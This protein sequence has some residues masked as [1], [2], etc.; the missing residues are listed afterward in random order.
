MVRERGVEAAGRD[1][2][3]HNGEKKMPGYYTPLNQ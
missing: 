1:E 2:K 3:V